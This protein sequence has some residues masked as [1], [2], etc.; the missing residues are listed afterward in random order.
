MKEKEAEMKDRRK[1]ERRERNRRL[2]V[3][4]TNAACKTYLLS[5]FFLI[6]FLASIR[7]ACDGNE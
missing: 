6:S 1:R 3:K 7:V 2:R 5:N 4:K